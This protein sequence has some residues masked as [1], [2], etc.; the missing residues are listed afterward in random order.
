M[1]ELKVIESGIVPVYKDSEDRAL[2]NARE[3]HEFL[4]VGKKFADWIR[5]RIGQY[6]FLEGTE[7]FPILG[8]TSE[9]GGR[10]ATEYLLTIDVAKEIA[11]LEN[12]EKGRQVRRY[13][14]E[15]EKRLRAV[16]GAISA[17]DAEKVKSTPCELGSLFKT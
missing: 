9:T 3:M 11:M 4:D 12:N 2:I 5:Y 6:G 15:C 14:I 7:F 13:F 1:K 8:K 16:S 17:K 10:P